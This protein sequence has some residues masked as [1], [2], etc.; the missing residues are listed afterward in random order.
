M[1]SEVN[2]SQISLIDCWTHLKG[3]MQFAMSCSDL[4]CNFVFGQF[5][6]ARLPT[7]STRVFL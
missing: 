1:Y 3:A 6:L 7:E 4:L 5:S 2:D